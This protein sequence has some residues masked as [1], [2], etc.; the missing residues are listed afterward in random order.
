MT[1]KF[2]I[3]VECVNVGHSGEVVEDGLDFFVERRS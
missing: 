3:E 1:I 2:S